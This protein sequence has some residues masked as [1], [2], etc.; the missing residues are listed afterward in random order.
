MKDLVILLPTC[1]Q[2]MFK[3]CLGTHEESPF[4]ST[5]CSSEV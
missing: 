5:R 3:R 2:D 1:R 4:S